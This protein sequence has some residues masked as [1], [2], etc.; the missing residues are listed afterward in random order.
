MAENVPARPGLCGRAAWSSA[1]TVRPGG[2]AILYRRRSARDP[3]AAQ[4]VS[5]RKE[6]ARNPT[7]RWEIVVTQ[8]PSIFTS[9]LCPSELRMGTL[10]DI[11]RAGAW[12]FWTILRA[13]KVLVLIGLGL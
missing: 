13:L 2:S 7:A 4:A 3:N 10:W 9:I 6:S 5:K 8:N 1:R 11:C 12:G